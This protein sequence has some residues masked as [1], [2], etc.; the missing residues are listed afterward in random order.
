MQYLQKNFDDR[1]SLISYVSELSPW[2]ESDPSN[3]GGNRHQ[4]GSKLTAIN[5]I[6]Y[7]RT[8]NFGDGKVTCLASYTHHG[9]LS[10]NEV[11]NHAL[12]K[13][14]EPIQIPKFIQELVLQYW[15]EA[16]KKAFL[17]NGGLNA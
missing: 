17:K 2:A 14:I 1:A 9:I 15:K 16:E 12:E 10:L 5:P 3:I 8:P 11:G 13:C 7:S 6:A 4:A